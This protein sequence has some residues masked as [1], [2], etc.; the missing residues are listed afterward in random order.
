MVFHL[1]LSNAKRFTEDGVDGIVRW[2][3][4]AKMHRDFAKIF[5]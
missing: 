1:P 2:K 5:T 4:N 3:N